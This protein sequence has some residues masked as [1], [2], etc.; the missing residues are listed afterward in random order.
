MLPILLAAVAVYLGRG[1]E[2]VASF[3]HRGLAMRRGCGH[4]LNAD[5]R[6]PRP[7]YL[8]G[9]AAWASH[10]TLIGLKLRGCVS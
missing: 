5:W 6:C 1:D 2:V 3:A 10:Q 4:P 7:A 8:L 9:E